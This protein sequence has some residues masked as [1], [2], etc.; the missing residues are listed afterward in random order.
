MSGTP[1]EYT[2]EGIPRFSGFWENP[3]HAAAV[4]AS[5]IPIVWWAQRKLA[6][7]TAW[8]AWTIFAWV[9]EAALG[10]L[11]GLT[12]SRGGALAWLCAIVFYGIY[13]DRDFE[14]SSKK[15]N[16]SRNSLLSHLLIFPV[17]LIFTGLSHRFVSIANGDASGTNRL[18]LWSGALSLIEASPLT[19]WGKGN[20]GLAFMQWVQTPDREVAYSGMVNSYLQVAVE[21]GLPALVLLFFVASFLVAAPLRYAR[22][23]ESGTRDFVFACDAGLIAFII[24][25]F[26]TTTITHISVYLAF[27]FLAALILAGTYGPSMQTTILRHSVIAL[28]IAVLAGSA[29]Y[30]AAL[31]LPTRMPWRLT[32]SPDGS[33][34]FSPRESPR[35]GRSIALL[36]DQRTLGRYYGKELRRVMEL[37]LNQI[38]T[39]TIYPAGVHL[40]PNLLGNVFVFGPRVSD[41]SK[42]DA[43]TRLFLIAPVGPSSVADKVDSGTIV[44]LPSIDQIGDASVWRTWAKRSD[45]RL[46]LLAGTGQ[47]IRR[48]WPRVFAQCLTLIP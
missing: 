23:L 8:P 24:A 26:F 18:E 4:L 16:S 25:S 47:D 1:Y 43:P 30:L 37:H 39:L 20:S 38:Q 3:N 46:E 42:R 40:P 31:L 44:I 5:V 10:L 21:F 15:A 17:I 19:G 36:P 45:C 29:L 11:I 13:C 35:V 27:I 32:Q 2:Y 6:G 22:T 41:L 12:Y 9:L 28:C 33:I 48:E 14:E 34:I 7:F